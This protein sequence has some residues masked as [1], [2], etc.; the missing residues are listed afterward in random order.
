MLNDKKLIE[1]ATN[2]LTKTLI[3]KRLAELRFYEFV[4]QAWQHI[5]PNVYE[6]NWHIKFLCDHLQAFH[7]NVFE[8]L[9]INIP[10]GFAKS[11]IVSVLY[12]CWVW[13]NEPNFRFL[14]GSGASDLAVRDCRKARD[15]LACDWYQK[16]WGHTWKFKSDENQKSSYENDKGG[17]RN[18]FSSQGRV[19][20]FRGD[21]RLFDDPH[22]ARF[23]R[24]TEHLKKD[25][26]WFD[27]VFSSRGDVLKPS[28]TLVIMQR[29]SPYDLTGHIL[30]QKLDNWTL[31]CLPWEFETECKCVTLIGEDIRKEEKEVLWNNSE[32]IANMTKLKRSLGSDGAA[33]QLQQRPVIPGGNIIKREWLQLCSSLPPSFDFKIQA[34][35]GAWETKKENDYSVCATF[36]ALGEN[37]YLIDLWRD[38]VIYPDF[39]KM[40]IFQNDKHRPARQYIEKAASGIAAIQE[41]EKDSRLSIDKVTPEG[42]KEN[43]AYACTPFLENL[44]FFIYDK[45]AGVEDYIDELISFPKGLHDDM[46]DATTMG[47]NG[48]K[49]FNRS[50]ISIF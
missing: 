27:T 21:E 6:D 41:L 19:T 50:P 22:D 43:R 33:G 24:D 36:G 11:L 29:L 7:E 14:T 44:H 16:N 4:K 20:G 35:D 39:K 42:S 47:I 38:K 46:V 28:K 2:P 13:I 26:F 25:C 48:F 34:I 32:V 45:I 17:F 31:I 15:L 18:M 5:D 40:I 23:S 49:T 10:P 30:S 8:N 3:D 1:L 9:I 37:L 12:P